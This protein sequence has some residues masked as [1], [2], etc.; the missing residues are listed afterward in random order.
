MRRCS[1]FAFRW[2]S[3]A[4]LVALLGLAATCAAASAQVIRFHGYRL[5]VPSGW[6]VY[7]LARRPRTCVRFDRHAVYLGS[8]SARQ[9]CPAAAIGR[10]EA[11]LVSPLSAR[12]AGTRGGG[13]ALPLVT[14][15]GAQSRQGSLARFAVVAHGVT[16]TATW[17]RA[18]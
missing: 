6:P 8:P 9:R 16:V 3:A 17:A 5:S 14:R 7:Q 13:P 1:I 15:P 4:A 12:D 10:T 11:I 18:G 2:I